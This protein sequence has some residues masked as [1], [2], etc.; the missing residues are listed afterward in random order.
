MVFDAIYFLIVVRKGKVS[1]LSS[2]VEV[3]HLEGQNF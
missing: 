3:E 2:F 1:I